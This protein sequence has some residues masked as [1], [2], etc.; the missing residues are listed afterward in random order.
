MVVITHNQVGVYVEIHK[1]RVLLILLMVFE[2][3]YNSVSRLYKGAAVPG[4]DSTE[5]GNHPEPLVRR[6]MEV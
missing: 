2:R 1:V 3:S 4:L 6:C 5:K